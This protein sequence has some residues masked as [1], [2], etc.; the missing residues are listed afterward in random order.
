M[1]RGA[2]LHT[3]QSFDGTLRN[4]VLS[5]P[6]RNPLAGIGPKGTF[7]HGRAD[8]I[9]P[10]ERIHALAAEEGSR[11]VETGDEHLSYSFRNPGTIVEVI[12]S[13]TGGSAPGPGAGR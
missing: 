11:V 5:Q 6:I 7:I 13:P 4:V 10:L 3:W 1:P 12:A 8:G 9:T 2:M